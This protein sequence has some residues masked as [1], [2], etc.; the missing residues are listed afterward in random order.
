MVGWA[1]PIEAKYL[2][3]EVHSLMK[4]DRPVIR[5]QDLD[6]VVLLVS[7]PLEKLKA[8]APWVWRY[9]RYGMTATFA[10]EKSKGKPVP[11]R[12]TCAARDP[13]YDLTMLP[14]SE[15]HVCDLAV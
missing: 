7:E 10:S 13:W 4:L 2:A 5:A 3:P 14:A 9:L 6:R 11:E 1:P 8:K 12:S 15:R